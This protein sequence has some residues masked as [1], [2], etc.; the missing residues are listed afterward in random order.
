MFWSNSAGAQVLGLPGEITVEELYGPPRLP[1]TLQLTFWG[2]VKVNGMQVELKPFSSD[3]MMLRRYY[4][5][6]MLTPPPTQTML[7]QR[8][9]GLGGGLVLFIGAVVALDVAVINELTGAPRSAKMVTW[10]VVGL[11]AGTSILTISLL[12]SNRKISH[13]YGDWAV[14]NP[15]HIRLR[16]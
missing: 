16:R 12:P 3:A 1:E 13:A 4:R 14:Q 10:G 15:E 9:L 8:E 6:V 7:R 11:F 2:R 5:K